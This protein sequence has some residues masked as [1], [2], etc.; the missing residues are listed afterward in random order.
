MVLLEQFRVQRKLALFEHF[1]QV[2]QHAFADAGDGE[3]FLGFVDQVGN[4]L[5]LGLDGFGGVAV[6]ANA[7]GILAVDFE[8]I[9]GFVEYAGDGFV[10]HCG[11]D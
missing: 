1:L 6:G 10:I 7:K 3:H 4:L 8:Q 9:G 5:G 11:K 2:Y